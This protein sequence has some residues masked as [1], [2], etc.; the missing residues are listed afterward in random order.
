MVDEGFSEDAFV[1]ILLLLPTSARRRC[2]LV[3]RRWRDVIDECT[4]ERQVRTKI[5]AVVNDCGEAAYVYDGHDG[6]R[7]HM[8]MYWPE[9][10]DVHMVGTCNGLICLHDSGML[11]DGSLSTITVANPMTGEKLALPPV[12]AASP[13]SRSSGTYAFGYHPTTGRYKVVHLPCH[14]AR[15]TFDAVQV[16]T[17]GDDSSWREVAAAALATGASYNPSCG[18]VTVDGS[19]Y[20]FT[21]SADRVVALDL[22]EDE[23]VTSFDAPPPVRPVQTPEEASWQVTAVH[24]RLGVA[25]SYREPTMT[26]VEVWVAEGGAGERRRRWSQMYSL[27]ERGFADGG[28]WIITAPH[29]TYGEHI[30]TRNRTELY[31]RKV[32]GR[33]SG[34]EVTQL[35]PSEGAQLVMSYEIYGIGSTFAYVETREPVPR[36]AGDGGDGASKP[37]QGASVVNPRLPETYSELLSCKRRKIDSD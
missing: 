16:F 25:V 17:L 8:W 12:P 11:G 13:Q 34:G 28:G 4:P 9:H 37:A 15:P 22:G 35:R 6:R 33:T 23:R 1:Q 31:R 2:R 32:D 29:L 24:A 36:F 21:A 19:A 26:R 20:W 27:V 10:G 7:L 30:L 14:R 5:L 18:I 3:C